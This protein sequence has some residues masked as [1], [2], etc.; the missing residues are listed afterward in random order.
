MGRSLSAGVVAFSPA[1]E[2]AARFRS[3][4]GAREMSLIIE[5]CVCECVHFKA[6]YVC[7]NVPNTR[8]LAS[9]VCLCLCLYAYTHTHKIAYLT[10]LLPFSLAPAHPMYAATSRRGDGGSTPNAIIAGVCLRARACPCASRLPR[11]SFARFC[12]IY[13]SKH[14]A[15][16]PYHAAAAH[17]RCGG[18]RTSVI[19]FKRPTRIVS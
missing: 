8:A 7:M 3:C 4:R 10:G 11:V 18:T 5:T 14:K 6:F 15:R 1:L 13:T 2:R 9:G 17:M 19:I 12:N 16:A